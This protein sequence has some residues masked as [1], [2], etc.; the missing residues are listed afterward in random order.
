MWSARSSNVVTNA[1]LDKSLSSESFSLVLLPGNSLA[2]ATV[3]N[4]ARRDGRASSCPE[5]LAS[6]FAARSHAVRMIVAEAV[7]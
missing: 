1:S 5:P 2:F 3:A 7:T 6:I 4:A